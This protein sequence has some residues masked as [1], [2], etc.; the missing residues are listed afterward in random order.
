MSSA[1]DRGRR[2]VCGGLGGRFFDLIVKPSAVSSKRKRYLRKGKLLWYPLRVLSSL[3]I[4]FY[5]D[6]AAVL[7]TVYTSYSV[8]YTFQVAVPVIFAEIYGYNELE[9]G[10]ALPPLFF[11]FTLGTF[12]LVS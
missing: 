5:P 4:I 7:W 3:R 10:L 11:G 6:V 2:R 12:L 1:T 9:I 8:Y